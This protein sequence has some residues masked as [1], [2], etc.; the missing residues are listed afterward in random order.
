MEKESA[1]ERK[2]LAKE[3]LEKLVIR[4]L[5]AKRKCL[6]F[7]QVHLVKELDLPCVGKDLHGLW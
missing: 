6:F 2:I 5:L 4:V 7:T 3:N 1:G